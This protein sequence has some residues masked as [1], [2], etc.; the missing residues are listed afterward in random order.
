MALIIMCH[1]S[2]AAFLQ[3]QARLGPVERLDL[4][5]LIETEDDGMGGRI[6][7]EADHVAQLVN[8]LGVV[9]E[10]EL[11]HPMRLEAMCAPDPLDGADADPGSLSHHGASPVRCLARR[12]AE[13]QRDDALG[14]FAAERFNARRPRLVTKQALE[15]FL[16]EA[17]LPTPDASFRRAA[18]AHDL[19]GADAIRAEQDDLGPPD[20]LLSS[21]TIANQPFKTMT[22][23]GREGDGNSRAHAPDLHRL[24]ISGIPKRTLTSDFIQ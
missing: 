15:A 3:R 9:R 11:K 21:V 7:I 24:P 22:I 23:R 13:R 17:F 5:L 10:L 2:G 20:M 12:I 4:A 14:Y 18:A 1:G 16:H 19:R 8:E 6:D